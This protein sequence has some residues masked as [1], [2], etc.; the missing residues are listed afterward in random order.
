MR[1]Q[2]EV[3]LGDPKGTKWEQ[4]VPRHR[5]RATEASEKGD[6]Y[7]IRQYQ[8]H[9]NHDVYV[10]RQQIKDPYVKF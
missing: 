6:K 8:C 1:E 9:P 10:I 5:Q 7:D 3:G 2:K 4:V